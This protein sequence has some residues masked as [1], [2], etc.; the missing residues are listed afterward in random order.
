MVFAHDIFSPT[1]IDDFNAMGHELVIPQK[2]I[3]ITDHE[4]PAISSFAAD[5]HL[6]TVEFARSKQIEHVYYGEG[7]CHQV[8]PE[9]GHVKPGDVFIGT[10]SHTVTYG[11]LSAFSTG[12]GSTEMAAI[13]ATGKTWLKVPETIKVE[14]NGELGKGVYSKDLIL[15]VIGLLGSDGLTYKAIE[16][17]GETISHFS[18]EARFTLTNMV[19]EMGAKNGIIGFD[20]ITAEYLSQRKICDYPIYRADVDANYKKVITIDAID[21]RPQLAGPNG[22]DQVQTLSAFAGKPITQG[23]IG[24]CTNGRLE[25]LRI[26]ADVLQGKSVAPFIKLIIAPA[27]RQVYRDALTEGLIETFLDAGAVVVNPS[28]SLCYGVSG[29]VLGKNDVAVCSNNRNFPGRMGHKDAE[30]YLA[31][32]AVVAASAIAGEIAGIT[33]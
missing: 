21:I 23:F 15:Y 12:V 11:A 5:G 8:I 33:E 1:V 30:I 17:C 31:S 9:K 14:V 2:I 22:I 20:D 16:F 3:L 26:A 32:P 24:S 28:C 18:M 4:L 25:D 13:W 29:G 7:V 6:K 10:D 19:V 27:S